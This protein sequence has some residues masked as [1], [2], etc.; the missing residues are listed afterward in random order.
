MSAPATSSKPAPVRIVL[1]ALHAGQRAVADSAARFRVLACGRR[2]GK[3]MLALCECLAACGKTGARV[4]YVAPTFDMVSRH[5]RELLR[6]LPV[7]FP[8]VP[9]Q[10]DRRLEVANG[11]SI[12]FKSADKPDRLRGEGLDLLVIDEAAFIRDGARLWHE[13]LRPTLTDRQGRALIIS[14][15]CG[16]DWFHALWRAGRDGADD[17]ASF[18][19]PTASNPH[20]APDEIDAARNGLP[21]RAFQQEY[22]A[23][24]LQ[25]GGAVFR[26]V[27]EAVDPDGAARDPYSGRFVVGVDWGKSRDFTVFVVMDREAGRVVAIERFNQI[28]YRL[29]TQRLAALCQAWQPEAVLVERNSI[30]EPLL[31]QL[32]YDDLPVAGFTTTH[33]S[34]ARIIEALALA[35]ER[36]EIILPSDEALLDELTAYT[37]AARSGGTFSYSAPPGGHDDTVMALALAWEAAATGGIEGWGWV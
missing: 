14:T 36:G 9:H 19:Y 3:S 22:L 25:D 2:W 31:E 18:Q 24:F 21:E 7:G 26:R 33:G 6:H 32:Q 16:R 4:W 1:P 34:K 20:I 17:T 12:E 8:A 35:L 27:R 5:W 23:E 10:Q 37:V 15:P 11:A 28:D 29:Q 30:G 13:V